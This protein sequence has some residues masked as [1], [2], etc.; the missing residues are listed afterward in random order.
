M[1]NRSKYDLESFSID[2]TRFNDTRYAEYAK[3]RA[4]AHGK[5][6]KFKSEEE[7]TAYVLF[8][9]YLILIFSISIYILVS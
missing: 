7:Q 2:P 5:V 4:E 1:R 3:H 9:I 8:G 6:A